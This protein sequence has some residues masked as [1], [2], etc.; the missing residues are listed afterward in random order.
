MR[1]PAAYGGIVSLCVLAMV[2]GVVATPALGTTKADVQRA[3]SNEAAALQDYQEAASAFD[4]SETAYWAAASDVDRIQ[5]KQEHTQGVVDAFQQQMDQAK[6][7]FERQAVEM[8]M[9]GGGTNPG[10]F[11]LASSLSDVITSTEFLD[12]SSQQ[13]SDA[14]GDLGALETQLGDLQVQLADNEVELQQV[15]DERQSIM[16]EHEQTMEA[17]QA[18]WKRLSGTCREMQAKYEVEQA[19]ARAAAAARAGAGASGAPAAATPGFLCPS[20]TSSFIDSWGAPRSGGRRHKG[21]DM[22]AARGVPLYAVA[23]G[24]VYRSNSNLGG[25]SVWLIADYG[26]GYYYAHLSEWNI[27]NGQHVSKGDVVGFNGSTG[28]A[29]GGPPHLHFE[30]HPGGRGSAAVNP[31]PTVRAACR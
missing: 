21:V 7:R 20:P 8:Y 9:Q 23:S 29:A 25:I 5:R 1:R 27:S 31:Y 24:T 4:A 18:A 3:C 12:A 26:T 22:M 16:E 6:A 17:Q 14:V 13:D 15:E 10:L 28:N 11:F 30:I 19:R 2:A